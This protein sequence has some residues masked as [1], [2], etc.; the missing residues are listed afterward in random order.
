MICTNCESNKV[1]N[2]ITAKWT[3]TVY[4]ELSRL[5]AVDSWAEWRG[6]WSL[7]AS[8]SPSRDRRAA[9]SMA[10]CQCWVASQS[11]RL[12]CAPKHHSKPLSEATT[13]IAETG[14]GPTVRYR[15][16]E[17]ANH[18]IN[19][20]SSPPSP[21]QWP[22]YCV[23]ESLTFEEVQGLHIQMYSSAVWRIINIKVNINFW[24]QYISFSAGYKVSCCHFHSRETFCF[25]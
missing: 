8:E 7:I 25:F 12:A 1:R 21:V 4:A 20:R 3:L 22:V 15:A 23:C 2:G 14:E 11:V 24:N 6:C 9:G 19:S 5:F 17:Q 18:G 16:T 13:D 10:G